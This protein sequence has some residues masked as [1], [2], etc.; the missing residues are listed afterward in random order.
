MV[1]PEQAKRKRVLVHERLRTI[2]M[3]IDSALNKLRT[4]STLQSKIRPH[5]GMNE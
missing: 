1:D 4:Y 3:Q 5:I 2:A